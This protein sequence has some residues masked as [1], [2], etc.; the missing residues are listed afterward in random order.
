MEL[1]SQATMQ[2]HGCMLGCSCMQRGDGPPQGEQITC[3]ASQ[4]AGADLW[5]EALLGVEAASG[6]GEGCEGASAAVIST[7]TP[8]AEGARS[9]EAAERRAALRRQAFFCAGRRQVGHCMQ[10]ACRLLPPEPGRP[11]PPWSPQ[12][13]QRSCLCLSTWLV[14]Q[15]SSLLTGPV[16]KHGLLCSQYHVR[17]SC[18]CSPYSICIPDQLQ[19]THCSE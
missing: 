3:G 13:C 4:K 9:R 17:L 10:R 19:S 18:Q 14:Q 7:E 2:S 6:E 15:S 1:H 5:P 12:A 16:A 8:S 11:R